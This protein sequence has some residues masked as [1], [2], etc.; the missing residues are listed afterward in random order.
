VWKNPKDKR[1]NCQ[2]IRRRE[3]PREKRMMVKRRALEKV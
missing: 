3:R 1:L 2:R